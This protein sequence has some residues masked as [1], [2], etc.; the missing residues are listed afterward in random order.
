VSKIAR[1]IRVAHLIT[2][3]AVGGAQDYLLLIVKGLDQ[4]KYQ[5]FVF[6]RKEGDWV[7]YVHSLQGVTFVDV[8]ALKRSISPISDLI[9]IFQIRKLC[10]KYH[11]DIL[12]THSSKP[13]V[14]GRLGAAMAGVPVI[15][16]TIHGFSFHD[17]MPSWKRAFFINIERIMSFF[18]TTLL[19]YSRPNKLEAERLSIGARKSLELRYYGIDYSPF[20]KPIDRQ[21][22]RSTFGYRDSNFV[23]GFTGRLSEQKGLHILVSAFAEMHKEYPCVRLLLVGDGPLRESLQQQIQEHG[24]ENVA[25]IT[26][27]RSDVPDLLRAMDLFVMTSFWE[28]LSRSLAEA[29]YARLPIIATDVGGTSDA[30]RTN[31]TGWLIPPGD[32][33]AARDA[34]RDAIKNPHRAKQFGD[35][36][37]GWARENFDLLKMHTDMDILYS[38]LFEER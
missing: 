6:G 32:A 9:A 18:T 25:V 27:F 22:L 11:I 33:G 37:F 15:V 29:M 30:I 23:V 35:A 28:G 4:N 13:G 1:R 3:F 19:L 20:E 12:H 5:P 26:G 16:H 31:E 10:K 21:H 2:N 8:P 34:M 7:D 36:G 38:K 17:F 24:I 14:V